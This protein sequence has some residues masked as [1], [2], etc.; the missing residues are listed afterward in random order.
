[1]IFADDDEQWNLSQAKKSEEISN[2]EKIKANPYI[3]CKI[4]RW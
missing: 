1:M 3:K 4:Y 2:G